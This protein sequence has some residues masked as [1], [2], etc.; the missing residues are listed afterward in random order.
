MP[1]L[2]LNRWLGS[3]VILLPFIYAGFAAYGLWRR[4][5]ADQWG[6]LA[7]WMAGI[8]TT[9]AV[10]VALWQTNLARK[11]AE[12]ARAD[13]AAA[14]AD[15][16]ARLATE[17]AAADARLARELDAARRMEQVKTIP[18]IWE[19][20]MAVSNAYVYHLK[21]GLRTGPAANTDEACDHWRAQHATPMSDALARLELAFS[22][23][24]MLISEPHTQ[25]LVVDLYTKCRQVQVLALEL[26]RVRLLERRAPDPAPLEALL[27]EIREQR[28]PITRVV[29]EHLTQVPPLANG[30]T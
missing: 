20:V 9:G 5:G 29:R 30:A 10:L 27:Q 7:T 16:N 11:Q 15:V 6:D 19:E 22:S 13:A 21:E 23:A 24:V 28:K 14:V 12:Q 17:L 4:W 18:P 2:G 26:Q 25:Q 1:V 8:A 3:V